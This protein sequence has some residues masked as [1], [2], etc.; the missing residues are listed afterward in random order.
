VVTP[1]LQKE[2]GGGNRLQQHS[3]P[4]ATR[5]LAEAFLLM[6]IRDG[7]SAVWNNFYNL[8]LLIFSVMLVEIYSQ[9]QFPLTK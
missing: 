9:V 2:V 6:V 4:C 3:T 8:E 5:K 1:A 7:H